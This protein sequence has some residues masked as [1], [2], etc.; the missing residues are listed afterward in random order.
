MAQLF[1]AAAGAALGGFLAPGALLFGITG[2]QAGWVI[3]SM[4]G[5]AALGGQ[6][7]QGPR[8]DDLRV[9]GTEYGQAIPWFLG[10][11]R[12]AGQ[13]WWASDRRETQT[14]D[15][16]GGKGGGPTVTTFSYDVDVLYGLRDGEIGAVTRIWWNG[17]LVWSSFDDA[18]D[19]SAINSNTTN[20]WR[21][22]TVYTGAEDQ[23]PD[24]AYEASVGIDLAPGYRGRGCVFIEGMQLGQSGQLPNLTFEV[25]TSATVGTG[26]ARRTAVADT[27]KQFD[28]IYQAGLGN[29]AIVAVSPEVRVAVLLTTDPKVYR[30]SLAGVYRSTGFRS[31]ARE[32]YPGPA[33]TNGSVVSYPVGVLG[34]RPIRVM[35]M[36]SAIGT[37]PM[38]LR[39]GWTDA[40]AVGVGFT[41]ELTSA[42]PDGRYLGA[43]ALC[44]DGVHAMLLTAPT[45][46]TAGSSVID[47]WH[48]ISYNGVTTTLIDTGDTEEPLGIY[49]IGF[50]NS[51]TFHH[52]CCMLEDD[53]QHLWVAYGAGQGY[54]AMY[55]IEAGGVLRQRGEL[56]G[57][58][59]LQQYSFTYPS[60]WVQG[61]ICVAISRQSFQTFRR[62]GDEIA[63]VALDDVVEAMCLRA[64]MAADQF[65]VTE[66]A[67]ITKP[68]R[69]IVAAQ[70]GPTRQLLE[71]LQGGYFFEVAL[72]DKLYFR[73]RAA[74]P[75]LTIP[76]ADLAAGHDQAESEP[77]AL[78]VAA[79]L[80]TPGAIALK[81]RNVLDDQ[82]IGTEYDPRPNASQASLNTVDLA[83]AF[84]P[85]EA[86][87][88]VQA[89][90]ADSI[91]S[92]TSAEISL[93]LEYSHVEASDVVNVVDLD[94]TVYR[95]RLVRKT[96]EGGVHKF[97][98]LIDDADSVQQ[99]GVT[100]EGYTPSYAVTA[101]SATLMLPLDIPILRDADDSAGYYVAARGTGASWPGAVVQSSINGTDYANAATVGE[102]AVLGDCLT[103]LGDWTGGLV[104]DE[105]NSVDVMLDHGELSSTTR[106]T[107]LTDAGVNA[108]LIGD[109]I[110]RFVSAELLS[111][112]PNVYRLT[113]LIRGCR[114][115]E[116]AM[117]DHLAGERAV[118]LRPAGLR[119]VST[120]ASEIGQLRYL[121]GITL[122]S[123][124]ADVA[125]VQ[126]TNTG[127][128]LKP[129]LPTDL[130]VARDSTGGFSFTWKR[131]TRLG[132]TLV[133][134]AGM[135]VPLGEASE[136]Y[137]MDILDGSTVVNS[138]STTSPACAY[139][140]AQ[141]VADFGGIVAALDVAL[142]QIGSAGDGYPLLTNAETDYSP[143]QQQNTITLGGVFISGAPITVYVAGAVLLTYTTTVG[144]A[145][146][147][148]AASSL[149]AA[150]DALAG[151]TAA[152]VG[153]VVT[154]TGTPG[155]HYAFT[156]LV[157]G[158]GCSLGTNVV[159]TAALANGGSSY[160]ANLWIGN[161]ISGST[162]PI[163]AGTTFT[164]NI[165]RPAGSTTA[166]IAY[167][168]LFSE[169]RI[170]VLNGLA[171]ALAAHA[172]LPAL[173]Y[174]LGVASSPAAGYYGRFIGP[175]GVTDI[176]LST[177]VTAPFSLSVSLQSQGSAP[178]PADRP[179]IVDY[180]VVGTPAD[181]D[182][183]DATVGAG[184][185]SHIVGGSPL[186]TTLDVVTALAAT[187]DAAAGV[188]A[189]TTDRG[190]GGSIDAVRVTGDVAGEPFTYGSAVS[191]AMTIAIG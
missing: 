142:Y 164:I 60:I 90:V 53:L 153:P 38:I 24:P 171:S 163:P 129:F 85:S 122:G 91:A 166:S 71:Q 124:A 176:F 185:F 149:A 170:D 145:T 108:M 121:K 104:M 138:I 26:I 134:P 96:S 83:L 158:A 8:L 79:E 89:M 119:K 82:Q 183:V 16:A 42:L 144:D 35:N 34:G 30:F 78:T 159:Q 182:S 29:P 106:D 143:A 4:V 98:A 10:S 73:P 178:V 137:R 59:G 188:S 184:V 95:M 64:G 112:D 135:V 31:G 152:A 25:S 147:S 92:L 3:G 49:Q 58:G 32:D 123:S 99:A 97:E 72:S 167:T 101:P 130:R 46:A 17:K 180:V 177:S 50:G 107:L 15:S 54:V 69:A 102:S 45:N 55:R 57:G 126:F 33:G 168:T 41:D 18:D 86:K 39:A 139:T 132:Y 189:I 100:D 116:W 56:L 62:R 11:P 76:Y 1:I 118:L 84:T 160:T 114:G 128:A 21:R 157:G 127:A 151:Y 165:Q 37:E 22:I 70:V 23:L 146:L 74:A 51:S 109:E 7:S 105:L 120:Q 141:Q 36:A 94:G 12:I 173:G 6:K 133:G 48:L 179:Q 186:D 68:V 148:G 13:I 113:R 2:A 5:A 88:I 161:F 175:L 140:A 44:A 75:A 67:T 27:G 191:R 28:D 187:I 19:Q 154:V 103:V 181:G 172:T 155:A 66:L 80:E 61:G 125:A 52:A 136:A 40:E 81:Y 117:N 9:T 190:L 87:A 131:R 156:A 77:L 169:L 162:E 43:V 63:A 115:T 110:I 93:P 65:D 47:Q 14:T 111:D 20:Y 174:S 150:I